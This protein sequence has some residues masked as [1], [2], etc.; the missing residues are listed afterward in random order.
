[1]ALGV[2]TMA[3]ADATV[4]INK[5]VNEVFQFL[6]DGLNN[7]LWRPSVTDVRLQIGRPFSVGAIYKQGIKGP[8][9]KRVDGDY[10]ITQYKQNEEISFQVVAGPARPKGTI[11][12]AYVN[13]GTRVQFILDYKPKGWFKLRE[14]LFTKAMQDEVSNLNNLK[15]YLEK[16]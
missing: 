12:I 2:L 13:E 3:H 1:M 6:A 4:V 8:G 7:S 15:A 10:E 11:K 16:T 5:P 14:S 9:G